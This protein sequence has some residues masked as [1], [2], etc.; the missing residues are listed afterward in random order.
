MTSNAASASSPKWWAMLGIGLG[1]FMATLDSSIVNVSLPTLVEQLRTNFT[2]IQW[3]ILSYLL[4]TTSMMLIMARLG[5]MFGKRRIYTMGLVLFTVSS[6]LC[7]LSP[8][9]GWLIAFRALQGL[10]GVMMF[11]LSTAII[12]EIF[13]ASE[14]GRA[15]GII[16][17]IVSVGIALGPTLGGLL[18]GSV[19]WRSIFL[20]NVPIGIV[21]FFIVRQV[22]PLPQPSAT[23]P[24]FDAVGGVLLFMTLGSYALGM[25]LGQRLG[26]A[27]LLAVSLLALAVI[28]FAS[29]IAVETRVSQPMIDLRLFRN[30]LL[31]I[32]LLMGF[33]VFILI[34]GGQF[35][36]P[37]YLELV[38]GYET[39]MVGLLMAV[40]PISMGLTA[41][42]SGALSDRFG[43]RVIS[44]LGLILIASA[45]LLISSLDEAVGIGGYILRLAPL[46]IGMGMFNSPNNSAVMGAAPRERLGLASGLLSLTRSLG[47]ISGLPLM[48]ALFALYVGARASLPPGAEITDAPPAALVA[49]I[50]GTFRIAAIFIFIATA[51]AAYALWTDQQHRRAARLA[52]AEAPSVE[53]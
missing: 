12:T 53:K 5:D 17:G 34:G 19:G 11:S 40:F 1:T 38:K 23:V 26:F 16:G 7:G 33:L 25:T 51:L 42:I 35:L 6:L 9:V 13:P 21:A 10:G 14:R 46:G 39:Q 37:F 44:L 24:R 29:L 50:A 47:Q 52:A 22:I 31:A 18:I 41:P 28:S 15:L 32:N 30:T 48:S 49:G 3:V 43:S 20:V 27:S 4:V 36:L 2:T 8:G 45:A